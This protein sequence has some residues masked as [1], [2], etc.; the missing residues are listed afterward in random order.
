MAKPHV[1]KKTLAVDKKIS[2]PFSTKGQTIF[3]VAKSKFSPRTQEETFPPRRWN[4]L[5]EK[6]KKEVEKMNPTKRKI[7]E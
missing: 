5:S 7:V 4:F 1:L 6:N 3:H 2:M